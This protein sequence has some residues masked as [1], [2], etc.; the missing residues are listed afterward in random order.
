MEVNNR[1]PVVATSETVVDAEPETIWAVLVDVD[2]WPSWNSA[3][4]RAHMKGP[5]AEGT[6]FRWKASSLT[7]SSVFREVKPP[8]TLGWSGQTLRIPALHEFTIDPGPHGT[9]VRSTESWEGLLAS[10]FP[11]T[12]K[13]KLQRSLETGLECLKTEAE[14]RQARREP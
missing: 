9:V 5:L 10:L 1:A 7:I 3:V 6:S 8:R 4:K 12:M 13:R 2:R 14:R 11:R